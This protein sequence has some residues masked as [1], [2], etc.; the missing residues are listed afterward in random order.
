MKSINE[1]FKP[2]SLQLIQY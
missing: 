1:K 2:I